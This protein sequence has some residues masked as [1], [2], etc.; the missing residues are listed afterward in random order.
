MQLRPIFVGDG[1][2]QVDKFGNISVNGVNA[3]KFDT[4]DFADY[5]SLKKIGDNLFEG[6]NPIQNQ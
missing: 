2:L 5:K 6:A 4:V 1:K 3:Y